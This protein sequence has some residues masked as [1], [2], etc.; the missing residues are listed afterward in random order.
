MWRQRGEQSFLILPLATTK[1][2][3]PDIAARELKIRF[4]AKR[5][6]RN[7]EI[8]G[9]ASSYVHASQC[10]DRGARRCHRMARYLHI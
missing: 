8:C 1:D 7:D 3:D 2:Y 9:C 6:Q 4:E 5:C 10:C